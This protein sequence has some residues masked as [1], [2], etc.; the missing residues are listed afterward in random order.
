MNVSVGAGP[1]GSLCCVCHRVE[2]GVLR[3]ESVR[4]VWVRG[5]GRVCV[6][7]SECECTGRV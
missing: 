4:G 7:Y 6:C 5:A 3:R 2:S 1:G